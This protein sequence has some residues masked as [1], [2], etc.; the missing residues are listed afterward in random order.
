MVNGLYQMKILSVMIEGG[1][2]LIR[3]FIDE[4]VWDE[5]RIITNTRLISQ[6]PAVAAPILTQAEIAEEYHSGDDIIR[7]Y[8]FE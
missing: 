5:A 1:A 8:F 2:K 3:S 4:G 6:S 7:T